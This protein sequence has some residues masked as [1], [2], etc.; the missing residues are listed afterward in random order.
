MTCMDEW[1]VFICRLM[2][3]GFF[4]RGEL[5]PAFYY[6]D[7][8]KKIDYKRKEIWKL[9]T[10]KYWLPFLFSNIAIRFTFL[11]VGWNISCVVFPLGSFLTIITVCFDFVIFTLRIHV[12]DMC[13]CFFLFIVL[14]IWMVCICIILFALE[15]VVELW[16][17][18]KGSFNVNLSK[19]DYSALDYVQLTHFSW[20]Y[21]LQ[22]F[23]HFLS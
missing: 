23:G 20:N 11:V 13:V 17:C 3:S 7:S 18:W 6:L 14:E 8:N 22:Y 16:D 12:K 1:T 9:A 21:F 5:V 2:Q 19:S 15:I 4:S 10:D